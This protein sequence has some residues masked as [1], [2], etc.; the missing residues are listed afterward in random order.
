[1]TDPSASHGPAAGRPAI[2]AVY[3]TAFL[4]G[5]SIVAFPAGAAVLKDAFGLGDAQ[6]GALF[7]PE[8]A[9]AIAG[10]LGAAALVRRLGLKR[11][12]LLAQAANG[13]AMVALAASV[14]V[15]PAAAFP[16]LLVA[17]ALVGLGFG[18]G[19]APLNA[20]PP[21]L[22]PG[23]GDAAILAQHTLL[24]LGLAAG[25]LLL[26]PFVRAGLWTGF[27]VAVAAASLVLLAMSA[28]ATIPA[29]DRPAGAPGSVPDVAAQPARP[30]A[31]SPLFWVFGGISVLYAFAEGTFANWAVVFLHEGIGAPAA[32]AGI[33][34]SVFWGAIVA[35]RL[36]ASV[37]VLRVPSQVLWLLLPGLMAAAFLLLPAASTT[38]AAIALFGLAGLG[39]S[40]FFPLTIT[41][42]SRAFPGRAAAVSSL[43]IAA[44]MLGVG[45][46]TFVFGPLREW[47]T[48]GEIYRL[49][50]AYPAGAFLL[51]VGAACTPACRRRVRSLRFEVG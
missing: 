36:A 16:L 29:D 14:L 33:A 10:S 32:T 23:R 39:C 1:M 42:A 19:G 41:L 38:T 9:L 7:L 18:A 6:Y 40:A 24:G 15:P 44:L 46:G 12:L 43:M 20:L 17:T 11:L 28:A 50:A 5:L 49:S 30:L 13:L 2:A 45:T 35:G 27:P 26:A 47:L 4:Q 22:F 48:F 34:L 31:A 8:V 37:L 3:L 21:V 51:A 25:P